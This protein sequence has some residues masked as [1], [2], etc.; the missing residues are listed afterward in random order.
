M[1]NFEYR[2]SGMSIIE[3]RF[4]VPLDYNDDKGEKISIFLREV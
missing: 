3:H 2:H 4:M 1:K